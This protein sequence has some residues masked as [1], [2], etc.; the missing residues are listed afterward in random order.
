MLRRTLVGL[1]LA[2]LATASLSVSTRAAAD[3][4]SCEPPTQY[5]ES[6]GQCTIAVTVPPS[7][8]GGDDGGGSDGGGSGGGSDEGVGSNK[9][10]NYDGEEI[11]CKSKWGVWNGSLHCYIRPA[12]S[13]PPPSAA[14]WE[15][16]FPNG[17]IYTCRSAKPGDDDEVGVEFDIWLPSP[18][19][20]LPPPP[21]PGQLAEQAVAK[22]NLRAIDIGIVPEDREDRVGVIGLPTWMWAEDPGDQ[23][24]GPITE[25]ASAGGY[26]V[27][28]TARVV[29]IVWDMGDGATVTC[30]GPSTPYEDRYG[31]Q[32]SPDCG[33]T[34]TKDGTYTVKATSHWEIEWEGMGQSGV[35]PMGLSR[36]TS[37][38]MGEAQAVGQR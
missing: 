33:H 17:G 30:N 26:A 34:Y 20:G 8:G 27:V 11:P 14:V 37:I 25:T 16:S 1:L 31:K 32:E 4:I 24:T 29:K 7:E 18:P 23:T 22:M 36:E 19:P 5:D 28:A 38:R 10:R 35:I 3:P 9:C 21:D 6:T 15:G 13:V 2:I 12:D